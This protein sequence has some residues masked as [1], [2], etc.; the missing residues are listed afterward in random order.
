MDSSPPRPTLPP[1]REP[2]SRRTVHE[3]LAALEESQRV[4]ER[5]LT[6]LAREAGVLVA[7]PCP[8]CSK[9]YMLGTGGMVHCPHCG[10]RL[11]I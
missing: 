10:N 3:R 2:S 11:S 8:R 4:L 9:A 6:G 1:R 7:G 5:T